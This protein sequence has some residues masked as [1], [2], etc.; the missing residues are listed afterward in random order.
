[1]RH[2]RRPTRRR[3]GPKEAKPAGWK[4]KARK[5]WRSSRLIGDLALLFSWC[6]LAGSLAQQSDISVADRQRN[7][8][9]IWV[10]IFTCQSTCLRVTENGRC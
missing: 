1:M 9:S 7:A 4:I 8:R 10:G 2:S 3:S 5:C 6:I